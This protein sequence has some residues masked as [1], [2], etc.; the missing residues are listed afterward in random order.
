MKDLVKITNGSPIY[1]DL[2]QLTTI[3]IR[4]RYQ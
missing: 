2:Y 3:S 4:N 1:I